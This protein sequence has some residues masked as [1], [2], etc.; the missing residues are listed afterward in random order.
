MAT[1]EHENNKKEFLE[2]L[3]EYKNYW[4]AVH[5]AADKFSEKFIAG[6]VYVFIQGTTGSVIVDVANEVSWDQQLVGIGGDIIGGVI[7]ASGAGT[8]LNVVLTSQGYS[9]GTILQ[10]SY[11]NIKADIN[12]QYWKYETNQSFMVGGQMVTYDYVKIK[13]YANGDAIM[14]NAT[15]SPVVEKISESVYKQNTKFELKDIN[16]D[17][18][19]KIEFN[20]KNQIVSIEIDN[21][22]VIYNNDGTA[23]FPS[24]ITEAN[25]NLIVN[26]VNGVASLKSGQTISHIAVG[27]K[28]TTKELLQ[29]NGLTEEQAKNLPVG[30]V[31]KIPKDV[32]NIDGGYGN[33]KLYE[34]HDGSSIYCIPADKDGNIKVVKLDKDGNVLQN[35]FDISDNTVK[36]FVSDNNSLDTNGLEDA[37]KRSVVFKDH[38][39]NVQR[40][41]DEYHAK[42]ALDRF[43]KGEDITLNEVIQ[44]VEKSP[45]IMNKLKEVLLAKGNDDVADWITKDGQFKP[46]TPPDIKERFFL[47]AEEGNQLSTQLGSSI[48]G[49]IGSVIIGNNDFSNI[50]K[51]AISTSTTVVGQNVGEYIFWDKNNVNGSGAFDDIG[52][53]FKNTLQGAVVSFALSSFFAKNDTLSDILGMDGTFIGGLADFTVSYTL[54]YYGSQAVSELFAS[55][56]SINNIDY[57]NN[58]IFKNV[59]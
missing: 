35:D 56:I 9:V 44:A 27:T 19:A 20:E 52:A 59:A 10:K 45:N 58:K 29:Y 16:F 33:I 57:K 21:Q 48:G 3:S 25:P 43:S 12:G 8:V 7:L 55:L 11:T 2:E 36:E 5:V 30:F 49:S 47:E 15:Q 41:K 22:K 34:G 1:Q 50:E 32:K 18:G 17:D 26:I 4:N 51:I 6:K 40:A 39:D 24:D 23:T 31:V 53:D 42:V 38:P 13:C 14:D 46:N 37:Y 28:Y 54:G